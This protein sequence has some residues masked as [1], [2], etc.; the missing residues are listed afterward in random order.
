MPYLPVVAGMVIESK[1]R[2]ERF[3]WD[4]RRTI[5]DLYADNYYAH[6]GD[7]CHKAGML[8][9]TEP[10]GNGGFDTIQSGSTADIPMGEFW[11]GG[12]AMETVKVASSV[13]HVYGRKV[14]GAES[15]TADEGNGKW[16]E[17]PYTA[18]T[19]G[20]RAFC[21]GV[22]RYIFHRY[23]MQPWLDLK[24]GMTMGPWGSHFDRTQTWWT[25]MGSWLK[26]VTR[27]QYLL[28]SGRFVG[29]IC[30]FYGQDAPVDLPSR[31]NLKPAL[32]QGYDYDGCD[33]GGLLSMK[34]KNGRVVLPSGMS[35]S[36]LV[37]PESKFMTPEVVKKVA[38]LV[39]A[40]ATVYG[41]KPSQ[42]PSLAGY[43]KCDDQV[44]SVA[45]SVWGKSS[46]TQSRYGKGRVVWDKPLGGVLGEMK[47]K[48]D[49]EFSPHN[50]ST[51]LLYIHRKIDGRDV[52]FVSN[53][54]YRPTTA[55]CTF[56]VS[57]K[58]PELWNPETGKTQNA[59]AFS[60]SGGRTSVSLNLGPAE[61]AFV[62]FGKPAPKRHLT[63]FTMA[64]SGA[65]RASTPKVIIDK[66]FY[67]SADGRGADVTSKVREMVAGQEYEIPASN[68]LFGDPV[69]LVVKRLTVEYH[70]N[71][72][73]MKQ[74]VDE[75]NVATLLKSVDANAAPAYDT[76][77]LGDGQLAVQT[78]SVP[79]VSARGATPVYVMGVVQ[80]GG[81][82]NS[83]RRILVEPSYGTKSLDLNRGWSLTFPPKLGAPG[84][85]KF[86]KLISWPNSPVTGI[87]YFSGS[88]VYRK[89]ITVPTSFVGSGKALRL[90]LGDVK[91]FA[92]VTLNG[93]T[94]ATLWKPPFVLDVTKF[95]HAGANDL[96][97]KVTNLWPNR[98]IG[99][100]QLPPD[101]EWNGTQL[102]KWPAWLVNHQPRPKTGRITF[103]TWHYFNKNSPLLDSGLIGPVKLQSTDRVLVKY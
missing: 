15:F 93:K 9:S 67:G 49:F 7:L 42:S 84:T 102:K 25:E 22:N 32:P 48:P 27:S 41:G 36:L 21:D 47:V 79:T 23:A 69:N 11:I 12:G 97:I 98:I 24:P 66:A 55:Q 60:E 95:V 34:V 75:N 61:S 63:S 56:R 20:D 72:K 89:S 103:E 46:A 80:A 91:N 100:E 76:V 59:V 13:A 81:R 50:Y 18:K 78:W 68:G 45:D 101:V 5:A 83:M 54:S 74:V 85:A 64:D 35:Y 40:G 1:E 65:S 86:D 8:F 6:F 88:A 4:F 31:D 73:A 2:S 43:P 94:I 87:K 77:A 37:L 19:T 14:V 3:L 10:Y 38:E 62:V 16:L 70:L 17:E 96:Q 39:K 71:G 58:Q 57:G 52:Y 26:Y 99:D 51:K 44:R 92:T 90:N 53:Q 82:A 33:T 28:Q 30:Y 29:D